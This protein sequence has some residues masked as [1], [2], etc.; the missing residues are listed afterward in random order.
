MQ[1]DNFINGEWVPGDY[2][3]NINPSE[4]SD[5]IGHYAQA[6]ISDTDRAIQAAQNAKTI[7]SDV[8]PKKRSEA[9]NRIGEAILRQKERLGTYL[10]REEGKL[11]TE[12]IGEAERAGQTFLYYAH[13]LQQPDGD[14]FSSSRD[15]TIIHTV[16]KPVGAVGIITPWNFPLAI[17][18]WKIAPALAF[19]NTVVFKPAALVPAS[20]WNLAEIISEVGLPAGVFNLVMGSGGVVGDRVAKSNALDAV[21]FT[22]SSA[23]GKRII[24]DCIDAGNKKVQA[25]MGGKN[26]LIILDDAD[27]QTAV[28]AVIDGAFYSSGQRCTATSRVIVTKGVLEEVK[29]RLVDRMATLTVGHA[30]DASS[31][32][33]PLAS[34]AQLSTVLDYVRIG[35]DEGAEIISGGEVSEAETSGFFMQPTLFAGGRS[36][37]RINQEEIFGPVA[38][39]IAVDG[40]DEAIEIANDTNYG[41]CAGIISESA[42]SVDQ[43]LRRVDA[44][45]LHVNRSTALTELHVP[46]GGN[47]SSSFGP[48]EQGMVAQDFYTTISTVYTTTTS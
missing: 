43:F 46:F 44:G 36:G 35:V 3:P 22:G 42:Q 8:P 41:L 6:T 45:M 48:R 40:I 38:C 39:I 47:K 31:D 2:Q 23:T 16:R 14:R 19:G 30:L 32:I 1:Y 13:Q 21:S 11:I 37:M 17:P 33:G 4:T 25:E 28:E 12:G 27:I 9:L 26:S 29:A 24:Q 15:R 7:W 10:A 5:V 20:A 18:A 34:E